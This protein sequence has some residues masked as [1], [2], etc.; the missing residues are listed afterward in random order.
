MEGHQIYRRVPSLLESDE[1][2]HDELSSLNEC[3]WLCLL[4][5]CFWAGGIYFMHAW[6]AVSVCISA[7]S[8]ML[9]P[10]S[11]FNERFWAGGN[12]LLNYAPLELCAFGG[13]CAVHFYFCCFVLCPF[14][15]LLLCSSENLYFWIMS[16]GC[17]FW[18]DGCLID[19][20][21]DSLSLL[22]RGRPTGWLTEHGLGAVGRQPQRSE[23]WLLVG[24]LIGQSGP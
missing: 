13:K 14:L 17:A 18:S 7:F 12:L 3:S 5:I 4:L 1:L 22:C 24:Q 6:C 15:L 19:Q 2:L 16:A 10:L 20:L 23:K 9:S 21:S 8:E 11:S